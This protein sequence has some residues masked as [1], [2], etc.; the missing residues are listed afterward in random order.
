VPGNNS[1]E[2]TGQLDAQ[3]VMKHVGD[4]VATELPYLEKGLVVVTVQGSSLAYN[5]V[6][7]PYWTQAFQAIKLT[8][9]APIA[10]VLGGL[11]Q[12]VLGLSGGSF[13]STDANGS[14]ALNTSALIGIINGII[15]L[16]TL[17]AHI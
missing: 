8:A 1:I 11:L 17:A 12:D 13:V 5:G 3:N 14:V 9:S 16:P 7:L 4:L 15:P 10:P 6:A 2:A